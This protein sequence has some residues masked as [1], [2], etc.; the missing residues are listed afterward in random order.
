MCLLPGGARRTVYEQIKGLAT[1]HEI[2]LYEIP[3]SNEDRFDFNKFVKKH[4]SKPFAIKS[5]W[6]NFLNRL[7]R[8]FQNFVTLYFIHKNLASQI[9]KEGYDVVIVHSDMLTQAPF[10]IRFLK[11]KT[12]YHCHELLRIAHEKEF[13]FNEQVPFY[14]IYYELMTRQIRKHIDMRNARSSDCIITSSEYIREKVENVYKRHAIACHTGVDPDI[15]KPTTKR[16]KNQILFVG[17]GKDELNGYVFAK[18]VTDLVKKEIKINF[19][20]VLLR[21]GKLALTDRELAKKYSESLLT[22][23][24][25]QN[26]PFGLV[27]LESMACGVPV[28]AVAEGGHL[29]TVLNGKT[30]YLLPRNEE[31]FKEKILLLKR[32]PD[33]LNNLVK[34]TRE[35]ILNNFTWPHHISRLEKV[36]SQL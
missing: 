27:P 28:L 18:H 13:F 9:D 5:N 30:G 16:K 31:E 8:D 15:F 34:H 10:L 14:K 11:T 26:E 22:L 25:S 33:I 35:Y 12:I 3:T 1:N 19:E 17:R 21:K 2:D 32:S 29:E 24:T 6:P 4:I 23:C 7:N 36:I 20:T